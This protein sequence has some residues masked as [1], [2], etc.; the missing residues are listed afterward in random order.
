VHRTQ[1]TK[2]S[3][4]VGKNVSYYCPHKFLLKASVALMTCLSNDSVNYAF[5]ADCV[6]RLL[7]ISYVSGK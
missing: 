7:V 5:V 1:A 2:G 6:D 4:Q 3:T